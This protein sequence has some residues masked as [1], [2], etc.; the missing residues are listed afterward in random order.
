MTKLIDVKAD[1]GEGRHG[2]SET[3]SGRPLAP[4]AISGA[5]GL[6]DHAGHIGD[7]GPAGRPYHF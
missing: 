7:D 5:G 2:E 3:A 4:G 1:R 6:E